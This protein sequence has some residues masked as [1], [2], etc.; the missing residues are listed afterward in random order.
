MGIQ[1][2]AVAIMGREGSY[3][4]TAAGNYFGTAYEQPLYCSS[5]DAVF[6]AVASHEA[7]YGVTAVENS[8]IGNLAA[9]HDLLRST[10]YITIVGEVSLQ[11]HHS[12]AAVPGAA[13]DDIQ[14]VRSHPAAIGQ[15]SSFLE[16]Y[17]PGVVLRNASDTATALLDIAKLQDRSIAAIA[18]PETA[19]RHGLTI[20]SRNIANRQDNQ[21]RFVVIAQAA[22]ESSHILRLLADKTTI[23]LERLTSEQ[24]GSNVRQLALGC[25]AMA[26]VPVKRTYEHPI[27]GEP[28]QYC[29]FV[30][31]SC[32]GDQEAMF[33]AKQA[34][35]LSGISWR[36]L[37]TYQQA[38]SLK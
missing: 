27:Q 25:F 16:Q 3:H 24:L 1:T 30:D 19:E 38:K 32:G 18:D 21:T 20:L 13:H 2:P 11:I 33:S 35:T 37:G 17:L 36:E 12:L 34:L 29:M 6:D 8:I 14:E 31:V 5:F 10:N 28:G 15:C 4:D 9:P 7:R 22:E 26:N 23:L